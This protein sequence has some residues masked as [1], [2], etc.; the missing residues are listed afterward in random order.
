MSKVPALNIAQLEAN[1]KLAASKD[2]LKR[3]QERI[4]L[5]ATQAMLSP[6][7]ELETRRS[8]TARSSGSTLETDRLLTRRG[9]LGKAGE[10]VA[11]GHAIPKG[12]RRTKEKDKSAIE[13]SVSSSDEDSVD[14]TASNLP[15][16]PA[17]AA[18]PA[19]TGMVG[20][21]IGDEDQGGFTRL[22]KQASIL[23]K[24][25]YEAKAVVEERDREIAR[26]KAEAEEIA[27]A[28]AAKESELQL[29]IEREKQ[30]RLLAQEETAGLEREKSEEE[31]RKQEKKVAKTLATAMKPSQPEPLLVGGRGSMTIEEQ[32]ALRKE[33]EELK[34]REKFFEAQREDIQRR[35]QTLAEQE[36]ETRRLR[37]EADAVREA[38]EKQAAKEEELRKEA[39]RQ[40]AISDNQLKRKQRLKAEQERIAREA[41]NLEAEKKHLE[42]ERSA[43]NDSAI[44]GLFAAAPPKA[45]PTLDQVT[46]RN[47]EIKPVAAPRVAPPPPQPPRVDADAARLAR[48]ERAKK[49]G[50]IARQKVEIEKLRAKEKEL[51]ESLKEANSDITDRDTSLREAKKQSAAAKKL[52]EGVPALQAEL[53]EVREQLR[54]AEELL[55]KKQ[56][57]HARA[58]AKKEKERKD[59]EDAARL[60]EAGLEAEKLKLELALQTLVEK[61]DELNRILM[62][63]MLQIATNQAQLGLSQEEQKK[64]LEDQTRLQLQLEALKRKESE[65]AEKRKREDDQRAAKQQSKDRA[66]EA[67]KARLESE[68]AAL[69]RQIEENNTAILEGSEREAKLRG[70]LQDKINEAEQQ[71]KTIEAQKQQITELRNQISQFTLQIKVKES[72]ISSI[73]E[74][75]A[76][77]SVA[78]RSTISEQQ[79]RIT[80]LSQQSASRSGENKAVALIYG[81]SPD[82]LN[83]SSYQRDHARLMRSLEDAAKVTVSGS[84]AEEDRWNALTAEQQNAVMARFNPS[85]YDF[86]SKDGIKNER[87]Y[88][89]LAGIA[90]PSIPYES[91]FCGTALLHMDDYEAAKRSQSSSISRTSAA[92]GISSSTSL[93]RSERTVIPATPSIITKPRT[94]IGQLIKGLDLGKL[95]ASLR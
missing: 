2:A 18:R 28:A 22:G 94:G 54:R 61:N 71:A 8:D 90:A 82:D 48:E 25:L 76:A 81:T 79:S 57:E 46:M 4:R 21:A 95:A 30:A 6:G 16:R 68:K 5:A 66:S 67:E 31:A 9:P 70:F 75:N 10:T 41:A 60:K 80:Y 86:N 64:L 85:F 53:A 45:T 62:E 15:S 49:D 19:I 87:I 73:L 27:L 91:G 51:L 35:L 20:S 40:A 29:Q 39:E 32:R 47:E 38:A 78:S 93:A 89:N 14:F 17:T 52:A 11:T 92:S 84:G 72:A 33:A 58:L 55:E 13:G 34:G 3:D 43:I 69:E 44:S 12:I 42:E 59:A 63:N 7:G 50:E 56:A 77:A 88:L 23:Q 24:R 36:A 83:Q 74:K 65:E 1:Q 26:L 37:A